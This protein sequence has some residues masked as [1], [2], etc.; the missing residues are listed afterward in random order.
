MFGE[1]PGR[2]FNSSHKR[3]FLSNQSVCLYVCRTALERLQT[4]DAA[5]RRQLDAKETSHR[6]RLEKVRAEAAEKEREANQKVEN[7]EAELRLLL[8]EKENSER[9]LKAELLRL[10]GDLQPQWRHIGNDN[11]VLCDW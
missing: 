5:F 9:A 11:D 2:A 4:A 10:V 1:N 3:F 6:Q 8:A 7:V